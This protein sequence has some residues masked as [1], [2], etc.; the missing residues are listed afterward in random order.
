MVRAAV[1]AMAAAAACHS[2]HQPA[3]RMAGMQRLLLLLTRMM[4]GQPATMSLT[5]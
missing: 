5:V 1:A 3:S 2:R 4:A